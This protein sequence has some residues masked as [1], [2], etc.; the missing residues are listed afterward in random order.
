VGGY[1]LT[2]VLQRGLAH[3]VVHKLGLVFGAFYKGHLAAKFRL[4][5]VEKPLHLHF[6]ALGSEA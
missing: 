3:I 2:V 4:Y 6:L 5:L 1:Y